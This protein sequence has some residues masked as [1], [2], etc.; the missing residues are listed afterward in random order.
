[1][2][3]VCFVCLY[4]LKLMFKKMHILVLHLDIKM[5]RLK[6]HF[7]RNKHTSNLF[8]GIDWD[9]IRMC[10]APYIPEVSSPTDTS[11]FD[12]D[13]DCLKNSVRTLWDVF[14]Q[15]FFNFLTCISVRNPYFL[16]CFMISRRLCLLPLTLLSLVTTCH[17]LAS[18]IQVNG[19]FCQGNS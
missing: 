1:M 5:D 15:M 7:K 2:L 11:N 6:C 14:L 17:L 4:I 12:V 9:N 18:P 13:D 8:S 16:S 3:H 10:E 19:K